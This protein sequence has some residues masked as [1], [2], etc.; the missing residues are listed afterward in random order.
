MTSILTE[1][2]QSVRRL[3]ASPGCSVCA[4]H[5]V[6]GACVMNEMAEMGPIETARVRKTMTMHLLRDDGNA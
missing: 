6:T 3:L 5:T 1:I 4:R 2:R